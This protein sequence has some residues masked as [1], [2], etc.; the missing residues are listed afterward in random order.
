MERII[1]EAALDVLT[2]IV[3]GKSLDPFKLEILR[4]AL[5]TQ[6]AEASAEDLAHAVVKRYLVESRA[7]AA[8]RLVSEKTNLA[9]LAEAPRDSLKS[10]AAHS[11]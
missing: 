1:V 9:E 6:L 7:E 4:Q 10:R 8:N 3:D 5:P 2:A 11:Y